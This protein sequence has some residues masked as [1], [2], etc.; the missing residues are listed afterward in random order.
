MAV[1]LNA[2]ALPDDTVW[3]DEWSWTPVVQA[4]SRTLGGRQIVEEVS[5]I[6][7]R[8]ITLVAQWIDK[9]VVDALQAERDIINNHM[10][11]T[12][13]DGR[14]F[15]VGFRHGDN[16]IDVSPIIEYAEYQSGDFFDV[17]IKLFEV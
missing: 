5:N 6:G 10:L 17:T 1:S 11:L 13:A 8:P 16:P 7:G 15:T 14:Q 3:T 2:I 12:V 9:S 4:V